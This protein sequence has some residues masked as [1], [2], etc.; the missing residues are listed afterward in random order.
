MTEVSNENR[1]ARRLVGRFE[2]ILRW[3][4]LDA[5]WARIRD[6]DRPWY[7]YQVGSALPDQAIEGNSLNEALAELDAL[8][9]QD[10]DHDYCGIVYA[11]DPARPTLV[12]V[13][14]PNNLGSSCGSSGQRIPPRWILSLEA[15]E[16]VVDDAPMPGN[17]RRWWQ[18]LFG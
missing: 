11:D 17:R 2:G 1:F 5:L 6:S 18:K 14:D 13:Y 4:D 12:K 9:H 7:F 15:P 8:L 10:H 16:E 3:Q